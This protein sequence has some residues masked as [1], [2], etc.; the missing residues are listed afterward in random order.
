MNA[1][2]KGILCLDVCFPGILK[3]AIKGGTS[4]DSIKCIC[5]K[6]N[7]K[8]FNSSKYLEKYKS[9]KNICKK[10]K[11]NNF[12]LLNN[13]GIIPKKRNINLILPFLF[14]QD[15]DYRIFLKDGNKFM[16]NPK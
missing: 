13:S 2:W 1:A 11:W 15:L 4:I 5:K 6:Q 14:V 7:T 12:S 16:W 9:V 8:C 10:E 3:C